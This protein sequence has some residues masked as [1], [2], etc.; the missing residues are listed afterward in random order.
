[1]A[2]FVTVNQML[3]GSSQLPTAAEH[4]FVVWTVLS[5]LIS[6]RSVVVGSWDEAPNIWLTVA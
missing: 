6:A 3:G 4:Y 5:D 2:L 1:M